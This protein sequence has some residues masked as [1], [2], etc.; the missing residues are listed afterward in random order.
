MIL[1]T[2]FTNFYRETMLP[3][4]KGLIGEQWKSRPSQY[5]R[6]YQVDSTSRSIEQYA[7]VTGFGLATPIKENGAVDYDRALQ[8]FT[9]NFIPTRWGL[10]FQVSI[11]LVED[12]KLGLAGRFARELSRSIKETIEI[13]AA[14][15]FARAFATYTG[16]DGQVLCSASHPLIKSGGVCSNLLSAASQLSFTSLKLALGE[17]EAVKD[18]TGKEI[19]APFVNLVI[20]K[21]YR[22]VAAQLTKS[23]DDPTTANRA[24]NTLRYAEDGM[25]QTFIWRYL[26]S[27]T[28]W[29]L[30]AAPEDTGLLWLWRKRPY[31]K[32]WVDEETENSK[33]AM[34]YKADFGWYDWRGVFGTPGA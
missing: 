32:G 30:T 2:S 14:L 7:G 13:N 27:T 11:D 34:R 16:P 20:P 1:T 4:F 23:P 33:T 18:D 8:G 22:F 28:A 19:H 17:A 21:A 10:G 26:T 15:T 31:V 12:D 29:F 9:K 6:I 25:P 3:A 24:I 5:S